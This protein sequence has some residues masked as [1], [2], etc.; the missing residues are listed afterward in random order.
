MFAAA[1]G[2]KV[3]TCAFNSK[4]CFKTESQSACLLLENNPVIGPNGKKQSLTHMGF[5]LVKTLGTA[6]QKAEPWSGSM[7]SH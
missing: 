6:S 1:L 4:A 7:R 5:A 3:L 2:V